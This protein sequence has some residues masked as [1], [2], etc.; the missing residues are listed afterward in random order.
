MPRTCALRSPRKRPRWVT[1]PAV[2][3]A[4]AGAAAAGSPTASALPPAAYGC[5]PKAGSG[6]AE[7]ASSGEPITAKATSPKQEEESAGGQSGEKP[8]KGEAVLVSD[9]LQLFF[10]FFKRQKDVEKT[11]SAV[12]RVFDFPQG[13]TK[14]LSSL[15]YTQHPYLLS[16]GVPPLLLSAN[17]LH[18]LVPPPLLSLLLLAHLTLA[19]L[20]LSVRKINK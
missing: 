17:L 19:T 9:W 11:G 16:L 13:M 7:G 20:L 3:P 12:Q 2:R 18:L 6:A 15:S 5:T 14:V 1:L 4:P 10:F 8:K